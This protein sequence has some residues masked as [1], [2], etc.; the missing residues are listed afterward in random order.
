M[1]SSMSKRTLQVLGVAL[2]VLLLCLPAFSQGTA[3]RILGT[4]TDQSGGS[5]AGVTVIVTDVDRNATRTL[6]T[7]SSG[8]YNAPNLL[9]GTYKVRVEAKGF[10]VTERQNIVLE[11]NGELRIDLSM[12]PGEITQM[13]MVTEAAPMI[14]TT[15]AELG[16]TLQS[17]V[18][19]DLPLNGRNFENLLQLRTGV[20]MYPGGS[21]WTQSANGLRP[22]DNVYLVNGRNISNV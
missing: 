6:T 10:K 11:V 16:G 5:M 18:I 3:G 4:V 20:T 8:E 9:P 21:A 17:N 19:A 22:Q 14:E 2:G 15:N 13:I 1:R 7:G 12:Q